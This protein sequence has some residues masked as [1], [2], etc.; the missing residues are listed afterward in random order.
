MATAN[1]D[2]GLPLNTI[3]VVGCGK[4]IEAAVLA[5]SL[6]AQVT[7]IDIETNFD[8]VALKFADLRQGDATRMEFPDGHFDAVYSFHALE[9]IPDYK[10]ALKEIKRVLRPGGV[11]LIG[12]PNRNRLVGYLGSKSATLWQKISWN[13]NDWKARLK[14]RFRNEYGAHAGYSSEELNSE[15][16]MVFSEVKEITMPYYLDIYARK[17]LVIQTLS[18]LGIARWTF[19][20][21]YFVGR[22]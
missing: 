14:G 4:G 17:K 7:G 5:D 21:V 12:T 13:F 6:N 22:K 11:W 19:P 3:L 18:S 16:G 1:N 2:S 15:L 8:E 9:H 20:A 10:Q